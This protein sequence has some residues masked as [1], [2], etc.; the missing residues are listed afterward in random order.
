LSAAVIVKKLK[1]FHGQDSFTVYKA[2]NEELVREINATVKEI[3]D[4]LGGS[5]LLKE[6]GEVY[7]KPNA[8]DSKPYSH[9]RPEVIRAVIDYWKNMGARKIF[10]FEN[11]TQANFTRLVFRAV[12]YT[13]ICRETGCMPIYLDEED[14]TSLSFKDKTSAG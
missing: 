2:L 4:S 6:S 11:T 12:G 1:I 7:I 8:V 3:F 14:S 10:L 5:S 9:T 13:K